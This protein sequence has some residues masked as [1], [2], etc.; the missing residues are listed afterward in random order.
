MLNNFHICSQTALYLAKSIISTLLGSS[1]AEWSARRTRNPAVSATLVNSQL[2]ASW[3]LGFYPVML[4]LNY[5]FT[6]AVCHALEKLSFN[7]PGSSLQSL[8]S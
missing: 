2:V 6:R 5:L 8:I 4:Y 1:M 7:I 3:Q